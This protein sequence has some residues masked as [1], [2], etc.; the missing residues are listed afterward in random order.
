M[1]T[2]YNR[3]HTTYYKETTVKTNTNKHKSAFKRDRNNRL[4][5]TICESLISG[6]MIGHKRVSRTKS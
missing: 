4:K 6:N 3:Q 1:N 5:P 2:Q